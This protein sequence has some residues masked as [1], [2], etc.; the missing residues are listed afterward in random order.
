MQ[1]K[2]FLKSWKDILLWVGIKVDLDNL[3][4]RKTRELHQQGEKHPTAGP[5]ISKALT[6]RKRSPEQRV[7]MGKGMLGNHRQLD[8]LFTVRS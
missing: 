4:K 6:G 1:E 7:N 3:R 8:E 2:F 5:N